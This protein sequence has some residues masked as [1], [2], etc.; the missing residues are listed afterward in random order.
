MLPHDT[1]EVAMTR[2][3]EIRPTGAALGAD[4]RGVDF[5]DL[6]EPTLDRIREALGE[7]LVLRFRDTELSDADYMALGR[8]LGE[9]V[10]P[11]AHTRTAEMTAPDFPE[12]SVISNIVEGGIAK[13]EAGE[14]ELRWHTDHGFMERPAAYTMLLAREVPAQGGDTSFVNMCRAHDEMPDGLRARAAM[15][16]VKHQASH[17]S[18]GKPRPG[19]ADIGTS[20]PR[21]LPGAIHPIVRTHPESGRKALYLGRRYGSYIPPL[22]L[23]DSETLLDAL[24][25]EAT[26]EELTWTQSWQV[27]DL[28]VW[29]N[30][31][32]MHRR[33]S[34]AGHGRR[35][36]HRLMT[37]GERP[38]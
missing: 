23:E 12:M 29:D 33:E 13:G 26:R 22:P 38:V 19:Y 8:R 21:A 7:H 16:S 11:E 5:G 3:I 34:F 35:R 2:N 18:T 32:T 15:L 24:W 30:R 4:V 14:G 9:I 6:D 27:G 17:S 28:I 31:C 37:L 25:A 10:P 36:M 1:R 20:D